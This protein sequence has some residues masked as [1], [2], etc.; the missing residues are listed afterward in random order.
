M[1]KIFLEFNPV[2]NLDGWYEKWITEFDIREAELING[3]R[4]EKLKQI[5]SEEDYELLKTNPGKYLESKFIEIEAESINE[6]RSK[7]L[8]QILE[9]KEQGL[10]NFEIGDI[11]GN[12]NSM[13]NFGK[14]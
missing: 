13:V 5:L 9:L 14:I 12:R 7:K 10:K 3:Y 4:S 2:D 8:K 6:N 1:K 11:V